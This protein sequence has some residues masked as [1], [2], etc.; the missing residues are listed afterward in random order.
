MRF[1]F[2]ESIRFNA[3]EIVSDVVAIVWS[4]GVEQGKRETLYVK[5]IEDNER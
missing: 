1:C 3:D 4:V 2:F 5:E